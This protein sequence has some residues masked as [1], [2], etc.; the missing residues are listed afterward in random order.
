M[1]G[2]PHLHGKYDLFWRFKGPITMPRAP[3]RCIPLY[4]RTHI[5]S[6][7]TK[8]VFSL[9]KICS[10]MSCHLPIGSERERKREGEN[11]ILKRDSASSS[12]V[13]NET[14]ATTY[15]NHLTSWPNSLSLST[16]HSSCPVMLPDMTAAHLGWPAAP[17][18][19]QTEHCCKC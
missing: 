10:I 3:R 4:H 2:N 6:H 9:V 17:A 1:R 15:M 7:T 12:G 18:E 8:T 11:W 19:P 14:L 5:L 13:S 16:G